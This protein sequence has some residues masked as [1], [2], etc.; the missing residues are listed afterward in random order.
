MASGWTRYIWE[1]VPPRRKMSSHSFPGGRTHG[2]VSGGH[3][4]WLQGALLHSPDTTGMG[5]LVLQGSL[6]SSIWVWMAF[7]SVWIFCRTFS[8]IP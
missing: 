4:T 6:Q 8:R 7:S 1:S 3:V 5:H 2:H